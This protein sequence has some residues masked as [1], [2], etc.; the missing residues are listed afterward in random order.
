MTPV[1]KTDAW[2]GGTGRDCIK[3]LTTRKTEGA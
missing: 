3:L 1:F 2:P